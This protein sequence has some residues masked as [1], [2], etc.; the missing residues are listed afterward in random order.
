MHAL[1]FILYLH[2][3]VLRKVDTRDYS[4]RGDI[5]Q[6]VLELFLLPASEEVVHREFLHLWPQVGNQ[7][8]RRCLLDHHPRHLLVSSI[9][10][11]SHNFRTNVPPLNLLL[12]RIFLITNLELLDFAVLTFSHQALSPVK[13]GKFRYRTKNGAPQASQTWKTSTACSTANHTI[14]TWSR[15]ANIVAYNSSYT[16]GPLLI[17]FN[18]RRNSFNLVWYLQ[19]QVF[20]SF[21]LLTNHGFSL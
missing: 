4:L 14:C 20:H 15:V 7:L 2:T 16:L 21:N 8:S 18:P 19:Q 9:P 12:S 13:Y 17:L 3:I 10:G 1:D 11:F 5:L 6:K